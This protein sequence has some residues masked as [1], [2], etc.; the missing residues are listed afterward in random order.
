MSYRLS[1]QFLRTFT[2]SILSVPR[3]YRT[4]AT[5]YTVN[6]IISHNRYQFVEID[7]LRSRNFHVTIPTNKIV[8]FFLADIGEGIKEVEI[9]QWF[10]KEGDTIKQFDK[11]CEV[12]SDKANVEISSRYD[13]IVKKLYHKQGDIAHVGQ[14]LIDI[15][16]EAAGEDVI[17]EEVPKTDSV[18]AKR[19]IQG[20]IPSRNHVE[21]SIEK[22]LTT[23]AVRRIA[24]ENNIDL[25]QIKA[26]GP[27]GR[28][29]KE[30]VLNFL[31]GQHHEEGQVEIEVVTTPITETT[32]VVI[33][34]DRVE[35]I[36]GL[37]RTMVKTMNQSNAIPQFGLHDEVNVDRLMVMR[38]EFKVL[39][40]K[41][42]VDKL[43]FM[44]F[45]IKALSLALKEFPILNS[46]I[47]PD[48]T[49]IIY[50]ASHNIGIAMDS[51]NGLLVPNIKNV[52]NLSILEIAK[53]LNRLQ[54]LGLQGKLGPNDLK[55]GT[56]TLSNIGTI[57]G[58]YAR[59]LIAPPEVCIGAIGK[60]K[61]VPMF[62]KTD[63][64]VPVH[65]M[66]IS[67]SGDHRIVDGATLTRFSNCWKDY[68]ENPDGMMLSMK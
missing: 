6:R 29:L 33:E 51:P 53:E 16:T 58:T 38:N 26:T 60:I 34:Q 45:F 13:G 17:V 12:E 59:P 65:I 67:W 52:Q 37:K 44:P 15:E 47:S 20:N 10:I 36:R 49:Q 61:R 56:F 54:Q 23:P 5:Q 63:R 57:G 55:G 27:R 22:V 35:P 7:S 11:V 31:K 25:R 32:T 43:T 3:C 28:V 62:D 46:T 1:K 48:E 21:E 30:D 19:E 8:P 42:G 64:V 66:Y 68:L 50:K 2:T 40:A 24:R 18:S 9:V 4:Y 41:K 14:P 39:A